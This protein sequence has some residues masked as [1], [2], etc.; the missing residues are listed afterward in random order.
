MLRNKIVKSRRGGTARVFK[1]QWLAT[2][3]FGLKT[4]KAGEFF[5]IERISSA[6]SF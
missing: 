3:N 5:S 1:S 6:L 4:D 2:A